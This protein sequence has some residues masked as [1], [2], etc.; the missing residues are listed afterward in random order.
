[1]STQGPQSGETVQQVLIHAPARLHLG[2]LD[3]NGGLGRRYGSIGLALEEPATRLC[4][5]PSP[6]LSAAGPS[7]ERVLRYARRLCERLSLA[8]RAHIQVQASIPDHVGLGSGT[9]LALAVGVG[10]AR[11]HRQTLSV[12]EIAEAAGRGARS[13]IGIA[14]F[15]HGGFMLDGGRSDETTGAPPLIARVPF[16]EH[17]RVLLVFDRRGE[18]LHGEQELAAFRSL[19]EFP[20][21]QAARLCRL[22]LMRMLPALAEQALEPFGAAVTELQQ[23]I[24]D[25]FAPAQG[26][27]YTS[28]SVG[29]ALQWLAAR[30]AAGL[31]QSSWGPSGFCFVEDPARA[32]ALAREAR[33]RFANREELEFRVVRAR[34]RGS[35]PVVEPL[36][37]TLSG[38]SF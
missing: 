1:M 36:C 13:G 28:A 21:D 4:L 7:A 8:P 30:G 9:Q 19:P 26:G 31:G 22:V 38:M 10:L 14:S 3:L 15:E 37:R 29:E 5:Q 20:A 6:A 11:L 23:C 2:F 25:H 34:N 27:R 24:G 32:D 35:M 17:W 18:G 33:V 16:P 12:R